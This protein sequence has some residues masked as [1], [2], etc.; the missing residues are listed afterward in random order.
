MDVCTIIYL[1]IWLLV[2]SPPPPRATTEVA[3]CLPKIHLHLF[4]VVKEHWFSLWVARCLVKRL[5]FPIS[6]AA[7]GGQ[8]DVD[9]NSSFSWECTL[10]S[11]SFFPSWNAEMWLEH[12][13][14]SWTKKM[15][16]RKEAMCWGQRNIKIQDGWVP[17]NNHHTNPGPST[18]GF[19]LCA[20]EINADIACFPFLTSSWM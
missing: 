16:L 11:L 9:R 8:W 14:P 3:S 4:S 5:H 18:S 2:V 12:Q 6:F 10:E 20:R 1:F 19:L 15:T 7:R 13:P 17:Q